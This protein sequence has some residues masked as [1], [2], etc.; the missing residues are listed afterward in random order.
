[1][2]KQYQL[3]IRKETRKY[4]PNPLGS[5]DED[6]LPDDDTPD[7]D[8]IRADMQ[9][10]AAQSFY[11]ST[12]KQRMDEFFQENHAAHRM[13]EPAPSEDGGS[14]MEL[15]NSPQLHL[16]SQNISR[17]VQRMNGLLGNFGPVGVGTLQKMKQADK[18]LREGNIGPCLRVLQG[19]KSSDPHNNILAYMISQINYFQTHNA[20]SDALPDARSEAKKSGAYSEHLGGDALLRFRYDAVAAEMPFSHKKAIEWLKEFV[21]LDADNISGETSFLKSHGIYFRSWLLLSMLPYKLWNDYIFQN[22]EDMVTNVIGGA[23][24]Y[25][26]ILRDPCMR[27]LRERAVPP[28]AVKRIEEKLALAQG[29]YEDIA[30]AFHSGWSERST[31]PWTVKNRYLSMFYDAG[32]FPKFDE[33]LLYVSL[34][35]RQ[36]DV[37]APPQ[38]VFARSGLERENY[39]RLWALVFNEESNKRLFTILPV[40]ETA[41]EQDFYREAE[42]ALQTLK[43]NENAEIETETWNEA[44]P[45]MVRWTMDHLLAIGTRNNNPRQKFTPSSPPFSHLYRE[46]SYQNNKNPLTGTLMENVASLGGFSGPQEIVAA[47]EGASALV[48]EPNY[49]IRAQQKEALRKARRAKGQILSSFD[50]DDLSAGKVFWYVFIPIGFMTFIFIVLYNTL[51]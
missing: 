36:F 33:V 28:A 46:W 44:E 19:A 16:L 15:A 6:A 45:H 27:A 42:R 5:E 4:A 26:H 3:M 49:G 30:Q 48:N 50:A 23:A 14:H 34:N 17:E 8:T 24:F 22:I 29:H 10:A 43:E 35:G 7:I 13:D 12:F 9:G 32:P 40:K 37:N 11:V 51:Y 38:N 47:F 31:L 21:L 20:H 39:W 25:I 1:M 41:A 18:Y 2:F